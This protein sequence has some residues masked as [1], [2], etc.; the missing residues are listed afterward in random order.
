MNDDMD[1][2]SEAHVLHVHH[3]LERDSS[4]SATA[5]LEPGTFAKRSDAGQVWR[6]GKL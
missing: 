4:L 3:L 6:L 5:E 1:D 2:D